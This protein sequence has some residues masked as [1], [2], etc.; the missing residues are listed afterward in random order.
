MI[1]HLAAGLPLSPPQP[2]PH[3]LVPEVVTGGRAFKVP[4]HAHRAPN[5]I[6]LFP[7]KARRTPFDPLGRRS[8]ATALVLGY[9]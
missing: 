4:T 9:K 6:C 8:Q 5:A 7:P 1:V 3:P 2:E